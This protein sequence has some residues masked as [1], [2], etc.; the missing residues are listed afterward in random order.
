MPR[1]LL[2][3]ASGRFAQHSG[4]SCDE[5]S[6]GQ[7]LQVKVH[8][9]MDDGRRLA[10]VRDGVHVLAD[11]LAL[12]S[13]PQA[14]DR[15]LRAASC[16]VAASAPTSCL[17]SSCSRVLTIRSG[18]SSAE[19]RRRI[20]STPRPMKNSWMAA[21]RAVRSTPWHVLRPLLGPANTVDIIEKHKVGGHA[22]TQR[23]LQRFGELDQAL[24]HQVRKLELRVV[25]ARCDA[26]RRAPQQEQQRTQR[27]CPAG[28][29]SMWSCARDTYGVLIHA[30]AARLS[31]KSKIFSMRTFSAF[32]SWPPS[33]SAA[34][35]SSSSLHSN[36]ATRLRSGPSAT[37]PA[38]SGRESACGGWSK[39]CCQ[40]RAAGE[41]VRLTE[42]KQIS[43]SSN[44]KVAV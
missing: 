43:K 5:P 32:N 44:P 30:G 27:A 18:L 35:R 25:T 20:S 24:D 33:E 19:P 42:H 17:Q 31:E 7:G 2:E 8:I 15:Q 10:I 23:R 12:S 3:M 14:S 26:C 40:A 4:R 36:V 37:A 16:V 38:A 34:M 29:A 9:R 28:A 13:A 22:H 41:A 21:M 6:R 11:V 1:H 39:Q